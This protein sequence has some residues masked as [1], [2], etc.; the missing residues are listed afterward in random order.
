MQTTF[1]AKAAAPAAVFPALPVTV[2]GMIAE[3]QRIYALTNGDGDNFP[4]IHHD[5]IHAISG[6]AITAADELRVA[7]HEVVLYDPGMARSALLWNAA[8]RVD[9]L[10]AYLRKYHADP[11]HVYLNAAPNG[12]ESAEFMRVQNEGESLKRKEI[13][14]QVEVGAQMARALRQLT[15][16]NYRELPPDIL[17]ELDFRELDFSTTANEIK[18]RL[19]TDKNA[20]V[21]DK[22]ARLLHDAATQLG[23][24]QDIPAAGAAWHGRARRPFRSP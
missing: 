5:A 2:G 4:F 11:A 9:S 1:N 6:M 3:F 10:Y 19:E 8:D 22:T 7:V 24:G 14:E 17:R 13:A 12:L 21:E 16:K 23:R 20:Q 18:H 15:G